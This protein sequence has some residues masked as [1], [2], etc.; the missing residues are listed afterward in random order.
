M[1]EA[2]N[3]MRIAHEAEADKYAPEIMAKAE[4]DRQNA[5]DIDGNKHGDR[6]MEI[7]DA[8]EAV[9]RAEDARVASLRKQ[10]AEREAATIMA[11]DKAQ[12]DAALSQQ[13]AAQAQLEAQNSQLQAQQAQLQ[14][15][16]AQAA[17]A[18]ADAATR[19]LSRSRS[20]RAMSQGS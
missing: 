7:T 20:S 11:K 8:R 6:K 1:H 14:A 9:E 18:Q 17:K 12:A 16:Q 19:A 10:A 13:Q 2:D 3:A 4:L 15:Q 5:S